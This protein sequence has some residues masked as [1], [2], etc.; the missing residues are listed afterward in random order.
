M[1]IVPLDQIPKVGA[2][3]DVP[4]DEPIK[5]YKTCKEMEMVCEI[6]RGVGLSAVQVGIPWKLFLVKFD[7]TSKIGKPGTYGYFVNCEYHGITTENEDEDKVVSLEGCLSIRS[8]EGRLRLF[9]VERFKTVKV[10][11]LRLL[12]PQ[13]CFAKFEHTLES[14]NQGVVF[15]H[16]I[17]HH[18]GILIS[19]NGKEKDVW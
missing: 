6:E 7:E 10:T 15:Q 2:L 17:D 11:G 5:V 4:L 9:E 14:E 12:E 16:E 13:L 8:P 18:L 19:D 3:E 1:R